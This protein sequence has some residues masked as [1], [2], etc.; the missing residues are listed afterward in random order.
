MSRLSPTSQRHKFRI[1]HFTRIA[2]RQAYEE[3]T[4]VKQPGG[5]VR[6]QLAGHASSPLENR[7]VGVVYG[8]DVVVVHSVSRYRT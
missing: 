4:L 5:Q 6:W 7:R 1:A 2:Y 8:P 3:D